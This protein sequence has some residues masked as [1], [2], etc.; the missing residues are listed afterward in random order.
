MN[1]KIYVSGPMTGMPK[2]NFPAFYKAER[3]LKDQ[4]FKVF[5][6]ARNERNDKF[7]WEDYLRKDIKKLCECD[8]IYMLNG[9]ENSRG[10]QLELHI[11]HRLGFNI[12][13]EK[14]EIT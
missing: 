9:W 6:P 4:G 1:K 12:M 10:A 8:H 7:T 3:E 13:F 2:H 5:N 14:H 11:A